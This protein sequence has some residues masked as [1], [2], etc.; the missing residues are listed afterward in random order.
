MNNSSTTIL[1][2]DDEPDILELI[3]YH[4]EKEGYV[5]HKAIDGETG[6]KMCSTI[7]PDLI[8][9][10]L[11]LPGIDGHQ[12]C[13]KIK[14]DSTLQRIPIVMLTAKK[15]ETDEVVG[16]KIGANDYIKKPFS[17]RVLIAR[18]E[19]ILQRKKQNETE[20]DLEDAKIVRG[21]MAIN[22]NTHEVT[23][24]N[25]HLELTSIEFKILKFLAQ[26]PNWVMSREK[27]IHNVRG[28]DSFITLR[29][30]DVHMSSLRKKLGASS[31]IIKTVH[32]EGYKFVY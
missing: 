11:M 16:L 9:L 21:S 24:G 18:I 32:G 13:Y 20:S 8:I 23:I 15:D 3:C 29:T 30:I 25:R 27:I 31:S 22:S 6:I 7:K 10:D 4:L 19:A 12:V 26:H 28:E 1:V 14:S 2:I 17:P 5:V